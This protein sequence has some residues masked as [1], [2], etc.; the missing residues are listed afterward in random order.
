MIDMEKAI[1]VLLDSQVEFVLIGGA[2]MV[3][4]GSARLTRDADVCYQRT[5]ENIRRLAS[6]VAPCHPRL[7]GAPEGLPFHFDEET[8]FTLTADLGDLDFLG[9]VAGLG[10]FESV[11]KSS[12]TMQLFGRDCKVLSLDGL[13][14]RAKRAA[15]RPRDLE[16]VKELEALR[17]LQ[18]GLESGADPWGE[19]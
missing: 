14:R 1:C 11:R 8:N 10:N 7:R 5:P 4:H 12:E 9:E 15:G 16:A 17:E 3:A 13:I 2:A 6:A 18:S 19:T